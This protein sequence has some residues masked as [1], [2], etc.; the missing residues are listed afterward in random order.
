MRAAIVMSA[1]DDAR[2]NN[3]KH[4]V[5]VRQA[6]ELIKT[7]HPEMR[8]SETGVRRILA[9]FRPRDSQTILRFDRSTMTEGEKLRYRRI[10]ELLAAA[11][12]KQGSK[13]PFNGRS[14]EPSTKYVIRFAERP[15]YPRHN[16]KDP[17]KPA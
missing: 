11:Q 8:I 16:R 14:E 9:A 13:A 2:Q 7:R 15:N 17:S 1:Y 4:S 10:G 6:A 3:Q 5:A 12:Q